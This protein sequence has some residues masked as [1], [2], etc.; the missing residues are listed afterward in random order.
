MKRVEAIS[1]LKQG[2]DEMRRLGV[3]RLYMFGST[4][5]DEAGTDSD[6]DLFFDHSRGALSLYGLMDIKDL[7]REILGRPVDIMTRSSLHP[8]LR[9]EIE[10]SAVR[11]F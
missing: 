3:L 2:E 9:T 5:R 7:A 1:R 6:V 10:A 8:A 4:A 11:V